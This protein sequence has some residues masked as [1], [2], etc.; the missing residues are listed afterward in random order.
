MIVKVIIKRDVIQGKENEFFQRLKELRTLA[1]NQEG[2]ITG[3]TLINTDAPS[4]VLVIS[5]WESLETWNAWKANPQRREVE[6][7][8]STLQYNE[9]VYESYVFKKWYAAADLGFPPPLQATEV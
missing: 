2:Y 4:K 3:E 8:L 7:I 6:S 9:T 5:K 1:L